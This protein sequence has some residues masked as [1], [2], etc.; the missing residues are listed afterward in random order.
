MVGIVKRIQKIFVE[1]MDILKTWEAIED[2][3]DLLAESLLC[4]LDLSGVKVWKSG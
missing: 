1:G 3:R 2:Q 4:E